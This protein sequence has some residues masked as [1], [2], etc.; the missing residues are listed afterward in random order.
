MSRVPAG[1]RS[2]GPLRAA[3]YGGSNYQAEANDEIVVLAMIETEVRH[4]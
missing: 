4:G 2:S 1:M 3:L